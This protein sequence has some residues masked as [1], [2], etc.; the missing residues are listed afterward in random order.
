[1]SKEMDFGD[2][3]RSLRQKKKMSQRIMANYLGMSTP[4]YNKIE[5]GKTNPS[6]ERIL[7]IS[8][9]FDIDPGE[10]WSGP[11]P[12]LPYDGQMPLPNEVQLVNRIAVLEMEI[13]LKD[14]IILQLKKR[15]GE[16]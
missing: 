1:M 6:W 5:K 14:E 11:T 15:L 4:G 7:Q 10:L 12:A 8:R 16:A 9:I 2:L 13:R 3:L